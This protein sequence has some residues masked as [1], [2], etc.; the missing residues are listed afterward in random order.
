MPN[1]IRVRPYQFIRTLVRRGHD[2][3]L[4]A[5][6]SSPQE[7]ADM[8][9]LVDMGVHLFAAYLPAWRSMANCLRALSKQRPLQATYS[10]HSDLAN[11]L[12]RFAQDPQFEVVHIE[13]LRGA[14]YGIHLTSANGSAA[15]PDHGAT[16]YSNPYRL[17]QC[18]LYLA[19]LS[20]GFSEEP[21]S[22]GASDDTCGTE[23]HTQI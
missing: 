8:R 11:L 2:V 20:A 6:W 1:R 7:K 9:E 12:E 22:K 17:G 14:Q 5:A 21:Q 4:L 15:S 19:P 10:W 3:T 18:R 16:D 23:S 13:H